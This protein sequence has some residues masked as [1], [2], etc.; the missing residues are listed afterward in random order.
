[1]YFAIL[2]QDKIVILLFKVRQYFYLFNS[3]F[4]YILLLYIILLIKNKLIYL[5]NIIK[6]LTI[7]LYIDLIKV[8]KLYCICG[9]YWLVV[10]Q[11]CV[12]VKPKIKI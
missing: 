6:Y 10:I 11:E 12:K 1:M 8:S 2:T 9:D 5:L 4:I 7:N 3:K